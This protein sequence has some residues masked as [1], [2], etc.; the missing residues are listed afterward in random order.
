MPPDSCSLL[1]FLDF[2]Q[3]FGAPFKSAFRDCGLLSDFLDILT[4]LYIFC[5]GRSHKFSL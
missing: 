2:S 1:W 5:F 4:N 3:L